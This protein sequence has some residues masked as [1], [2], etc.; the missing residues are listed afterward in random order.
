MQFNA[1][2]IL[3]GHAG[4]NAKPPAADATGGRYRGLK[5]LSAG[6]AAYA[7]LVAFTLVIWRH[8]LPRSKA[9]GS[10]EQVDKTQDIL[11]RDRSGVIRVAAVPPERRQAGSV[12][13]T[14]H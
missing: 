5:F 13:A 6:Q 7:G 2:A 10:V 8:I 12:Q 3:G 11:A 4:L 1:L 9:F 14:G